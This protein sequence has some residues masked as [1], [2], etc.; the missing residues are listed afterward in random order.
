MI[1]T[2]VSCTFCRGKKVESSHEQIQGEKERGG[3]QKFFV[4]E[5]PSTT[6][7]FD[8][9]AAY[10]ESPKEIGNSCWGTRLSSVN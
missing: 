4:P 1:I 10:S 6:F 3:R 8:T 7:Y 9:A 2:G 5:I